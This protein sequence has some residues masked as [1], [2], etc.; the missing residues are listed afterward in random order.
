MRFV[1]V[2]GLL[3]GLARGSVGDPVADR[4]AR[5]AAP[6]RISLKCED[7]G[8]TKA[9]S[10]FLDG[11]IEANKLFL[12]APRAS[13]DVVV[14]VSAQE[15]ALVDR[16]HLRFVGSVRGAPPVIELD[17]DID[18]RA[19]DDTQRAQL[20]P[21]FHRGLA[22]YVAARYPGAVK[23]ELAAPEGIVVAKPH[24]TPYGI[25]LEL[26]GSGNYTENYQSYNGGV[27]VEVSRLT[28]KDRIEA[29]VGANGG[30]SKAPPLMLEDGTT[31]SLDTERWAINAEAE[32]VWLW[33]HCWSVG[34]D[35]ST[36]RQDD[37]AQF[38]HKSQVKA[39]IE[40]DRFRADDPRGN[41]L[42]VY[43]AVGYEAE[44]YNLR[45]ELGETF[46]HY[47]SHQVGASGSVRKDK[48]SFGLSLLVAGEM[49]HPTRRHVLSASPFVEWQIG[50][51]IDINLGFSVAKRE[52]PGP[53]ESAIDPSDFE[54]LSRLSYADPLQMNGYLNV[55]IH[56]DR[57]NGARN[58]R[59]TDL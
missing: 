2:V 27:G 52:I 8:R 6:L 29:S 44:R 41:R 22:L 24:T 42:A 10:A 20:E 45:N 23:I 34:V 12:R 1:I 49:I 47:P 37:K 40:W 46:A 36:T 3:L 9:C 15:I 18:T 54:Q 48:I 31:I 4:G 56:W 7:Y 38:R 53:D 39:A 11:F 28:Q 58:D 55:R 57:T 33:N 5:P 19:D 30:V 14:Y 51:H 43:Y 50:G 59:L 32:A 21:A 16:V 35:T 17:V 25:A 13:A 26:G